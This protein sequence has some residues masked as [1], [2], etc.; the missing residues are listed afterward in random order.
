MREND[1]FNFDNIQRTH[2][3]ENNSKLNEK[4]YMISLT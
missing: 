2:L 4:S 1:A 3:L